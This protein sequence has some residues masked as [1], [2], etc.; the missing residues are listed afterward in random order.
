MQMFM[1][2]VSFKRP[3]TQ[4]QER[5]FIRYGDHKTCSHIGGKEATRLHFNTIKYN[6]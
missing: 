2:L 1:R 4:T 3:T 5:I 6:I